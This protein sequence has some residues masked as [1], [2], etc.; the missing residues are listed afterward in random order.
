MNN[1][2]MVSVVAIICSGG[3]FLYAAEVEI[4]FD[5]AAKG[6]TVLFRE[7]VETVSKETSV[8]VPGIDSNA[9]T[10]SQLSPMPVLPSDHGTETLGILVKGLGKQEVL[11]DVLRQYLSAA[12]YRSDAALAL[13]EL[14]G[15]QVVFDAD[16][17]YL[18]DHNKV[19]LYMLKN[20]ALV[21][22]LKVVLSSSSVQG[23]QYCEL[24]E[25]VVMQLMW[26]TI[27]G[28]W[29]QVWVEV[30]KQVKICRDEDGPID[31]PPYTNTGSNGPLIPVRAGN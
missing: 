1:L 27:A 17:V 29:T 9:S 8:F 25:T 6:D 18:T 12:Q 23:R 24:V 31:E 30:V 21:N 22:T 7:I 19:S 13:L 28:V 15:T 3:S 16:T 4:G 5:G 20:R 14:P 11:R 2:I 26:K 10:Q